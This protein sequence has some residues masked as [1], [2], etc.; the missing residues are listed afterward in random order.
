MTQLVIFRTP[1]ANEIMPLAK[2]YFEGRAMDYLETRIGS[3]INSGYL[4]HLIYDGIIGI[5][6]SGVK[7]NVKIARQTIKSSRKGFRF[8]RCVTTVPLTKSIWELLEYKD[9]P[10]E[11]YVPSLDKKIEC[12]HREY[13][14]EG[15][16]CAIAIMNE[17][18]T[19]IPDSFGE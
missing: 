3:G 6:Y 16:V 13:L 9:T 19:E 2:R 12:I 14:F 5:D 4:I 11:V 15:E 8:D 1:T 7:Y 18:A 10:G 17:G